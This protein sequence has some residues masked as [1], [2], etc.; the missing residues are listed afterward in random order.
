MGSFCFTLE[1]SE[2]E[3]ELS[4]DLAAPKPQNDSEFKALH[5]LFRRLVGWIKT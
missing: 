1:V 2:M 4:D 5:I 3:R